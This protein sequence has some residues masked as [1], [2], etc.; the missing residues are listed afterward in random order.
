LLR[1]DLRT[2]RQ[3]WKRVPGS[4]EVLVIDGHRVEPVRQWVGVKGGVLP[5]V[6]GVLHDALTAGTGAVVELE[7]DLGRGTVVDAA[8]GR[9]KSS[10]AL[11]LDN[12]FWTVFGGLVIGVQNDE[13]GKGRAVLAGYRLSGFGRAWTVPLPAGQTVERVKPCGQF[14]VCAAID[15]G[16]QSRVVAIDVRSGKEAWKQVVESG[17]DAGWYVTPAG[18]VF[19]VA[20]FESV[21]EGS[22]LGLDGKQVRPL[23]DGGSV[24]AVHGGR[25]AVRA[26]GL[27]GTD[28]MWQVYV[29]DVAD[30]KA[31]KG[32]DLGPEAPEQIALAGDLVGV[33]TKDRKVMVLRVVSV[34]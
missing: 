20:T 16:A 34:A 5:A 15:A 13:V 33:I 24:E 7:A 18:L 22:V 1:V 8:T 3:K 6:D 32:V 11:P 28:L 27:R 14:L 29:A 19:G 26:A 31:T 17:D 23:P 21:T 12:E 30:G 25:M 9:P 2:G 4:E 10:G